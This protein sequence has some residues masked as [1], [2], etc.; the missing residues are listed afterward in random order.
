MTSGTGADSRGSRGSRMTLEVL[1]GALVD[2]PLLTLSAADTMSDPSMSDTS[3]SDTSLSDCR[4]PLSTSC[5]D[6]TMVGGGDRLFLGQHSLRTL[7][8]LQRQNAPQRKYPPIAAKAPRPI[9]SA[10]FNSILLR[11]N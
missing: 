8:L 10:R 2:F 6:R 4:T 9:F 11:N 7:L 3:L 1:G 5:I